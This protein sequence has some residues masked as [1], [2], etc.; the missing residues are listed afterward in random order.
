MG[1]SPSTS[2]IP[3]PCLR[4]FPQRRVRGEC[5]CELQPEHVVGPRAQERRLRERLR[6]G[7]GGV[8]RHEEP[9]H[10][11]VGQG[12]VVGLHVGNDVHADWVIGKKK[13]PLFPPK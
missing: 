5:L 12:V 1:F 3:L 6:V 9:L 4:R 13:C 8:D 7:V 10:E 2:A 11:P